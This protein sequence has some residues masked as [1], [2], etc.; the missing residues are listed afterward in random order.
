MENILVNSGLIDIREKI[1]SHFDH[2]T[3]KTCRKVFAKKYGEDW[4]MWLEKL[5]LVQYIREFGVKDG[6]ILW[7]FIPGWDA[8]VKKFG[9]MASLEDLKEVKGSLKLFAFYVSPEPLHWAARNGHVKLMEV[10]FNCD[11]NNQ[12]CLNI[13]QLDGRGVTPFIEGCLYGQTG[14]VN[15]MITSSKE[16]G[17]DLNGFD[18]FFGKTGFL[19]ACQEGHTEIV[20]LIIENRNKYGINI[21]QKCHSG[22]T[23]L[24]IVNG[25]IK[26]CDEWERA[27]LEEI[28]VILE[29]AFSANNEPQ[30][31]I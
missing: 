13:N 18:Y 15:V 3:L 23:A 31:A 5:I 1:F 20:K 21:H 7:N 6:N 9:K 25:K 26:W 11:L 28:K 22:D 2:K 17:I 29:E 16:H 8:A 12:L 4:D 30:P 10:L 27:A 14:I 19:M 24:D